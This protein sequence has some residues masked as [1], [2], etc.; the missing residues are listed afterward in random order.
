MTSRLEDVIERLEQEANEDKIVPMGFT[1]PHSYRGYYNDLG[2]EPAENVR[3]EE[4][5]RD[6]KQALGTEYTAYKGGQFKMTKSSRVWIANYGTI[7]PGQLVSSI[8]LD[9]MLGDYRYEKKERVLDEV[10]V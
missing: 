8:L 9:Y 5:L 1:D 6:L 3:V 7:N 4:M 2:V 10:E